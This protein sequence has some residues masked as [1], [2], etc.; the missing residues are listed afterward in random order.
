MEELKLAGSRKVQAQSREQTG[1][2]PKTNIQI[3]MFGQV[4][5]LNQFWMTLLKRGDTGFAVRFIFSFADKPAFSCVDDQDFK[6]LFGDY[7]LKEL[8]I[9]VMGKLGISTLFSEDNNFE[10]WNISKEGNEQIANVE[11]V[12][13]DVANMLHGQRYN[14]LKEA[15]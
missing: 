7:V 9:W 1:V 13:S 2:L 3:C 4:P 14:H 6:R 5:V 12:L 8:Y 10:M 11:R 15:L